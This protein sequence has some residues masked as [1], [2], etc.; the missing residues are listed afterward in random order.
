VSV[1]DEKDVGF[2]NSFAG[3]E[4]EDALSED[5]ISD[6]YGPAAPSKKKEFTNTTKHHYETEEGFEELLFAICCFYSDIDN[7][8]DY[9][10]G[11]WTEYRD[12]KLNLMVRRSLSISRSQLIMTDCVYG[13]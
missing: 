2:V 13:N 9:L 11:L 12:G 7:V 5:D 1:E 6:S 3:L 8:R 10:K 4:V